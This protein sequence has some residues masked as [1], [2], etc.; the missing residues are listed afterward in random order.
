M[1]Q[2]SNQSQCPQPG[3]AGDMHI[4]SYFAESYFHSTNNR[5]Y[6]P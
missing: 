1:A 5:A 2:N 4:V 3:E 6:L